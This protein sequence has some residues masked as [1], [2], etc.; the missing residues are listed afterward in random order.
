[1]QHVDAGEPLEKLA[2][3]RCGGDAVAG[4]SKLSRPGR[5][6]LDAD[7]IASAFRRQRVGPVRRASADH[8]QPRD[9]HEIGEV[10]RSPISARTGSFITI[11]P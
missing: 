1:V 5:A 3:A 10:R 8:S 4:R 7:E 11:V 6:F 2:L 9:G